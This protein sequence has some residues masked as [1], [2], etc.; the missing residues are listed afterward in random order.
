MD[1]NFERDYGLVVLELLQTLKEKVALLQCA[2][3]RPSDYEGC[4]WAALILIPGGLSC[5]ANRTG[6]QHL[7]QNINTPKLLL[8]RL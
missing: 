8:K 2:V 4:P 6:I 3:P 7:P 5:G 1:D